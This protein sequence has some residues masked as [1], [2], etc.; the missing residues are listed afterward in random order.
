[1][2][3]TCRFS[4]PSLFAN[5]PSSRCNL[6]IS[7]KPL[8][9]NLS[10]SSSSVSFSSLN[11][12]SQFS[13]ITACV[14][15][16]QE[17]DNTL[18]V[19]EEEA[20]ARWEN[21]E[22]TGL[23]EF[24][25]EGVEEE[26]EEDGTVEAGGDAGEVKLYVGNLPYDVSSEK[27]AQLFEQAGVVNLAEVLYNR[28][29]NESRGFGFVTMRTV[30]EAEKAC[31]LFNRYDLGGRLL[32]VNKAV[33]RGTKPELKPQTLEPVFRVYV[34]NLPWD[35][36]NTQLEQIFSEYGKVE[37]ARVVDDRE[38][39]RSRG[40]GFVTMSSEAEVNEAIASLDGKSLGGRALRVNMAEERPRR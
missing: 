24:E 20:E 26:E 10:Y 13:F 12:K 29:T 2:A 4:L 8:K 34:G 5:N 11:K 25:D 21:D 32:T 9:I 19:E 3:N 18:I 1:M 15:A 14:A 6:A 17:E 39:G 36:D 27:L 38:S 35:I 31:D 28:E 22:S 30:E 40:F 37:N 23:S 16:Q 33:P 7:A